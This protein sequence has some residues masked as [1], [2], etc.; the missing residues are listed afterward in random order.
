MKQLK[1]NKRKKE[2]FLGILLG[3]LGTSLLGD[4]LAGKCTI[5]A[6]EGAIRAGQGF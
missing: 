6:S 2:G 5:R 3:T 1:M 4:H